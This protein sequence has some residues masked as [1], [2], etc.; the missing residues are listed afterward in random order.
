MHWAI[1]S[2]LENASAWQG[3]QRT[4]ETDKASGAADP[5]Y[6]QPLNQTQNFT[7]QSQY[8]SQA[9]YPVQ[10]SMYQNP[11][12]ASLTYQPIP[13]Q[14]T[15]A[16]PY[17]YAENPWIRAQQS[18][19]YVATSVQK[20]PAEAITDP[21]LSRQGVYASSLLRGTAGTV[22][23]LDER[24]IKLLLKRLQLLIDFK[25]TKSADLEGIFSKGERYESQI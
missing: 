2:L 12:Q 10:G 19:Q 23:R 8:Q 4:V 15:A 21:E 3:P 16:N 7:S 17:P 6:A 18:Q 9:S 13:Y 22:E 24:K 25:D 11:A 1:H 5:R 14:N 20:F